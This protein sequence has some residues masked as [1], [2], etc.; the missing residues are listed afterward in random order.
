[1][2][3][4]VELTAKLKL[5]TSDAEKQLSAMASKPVKSSKLKAKALPDEAAKS[6]KGIFSGD[7]GVANIGK[8]AKSATGGMNSMMGALEGMSGAA[9][10]AAAAIAGVTAAVAIVIKL[11]QGTDTMKAMMQKFEELF[12]KLREAMAPVLSLIGDIVI[13]IIQIVEDLLP[14]IQPNLNA[15][16]LA[17]KPVVVILQLLEPIIRLLGKAFE[18]LYDVIKT[19]IKTITFGLID[20]GNITGST[21]A[22]K[23]SGYSSSLDTWETSGDAAQNLSEAGKTLKDAAF[24]IKS[25]F[26]GLFDGVRDFLGG[27]K[28]G[29][30]NAASGAWSWIKDTAGN[31]WEGIKGFASNAWDSIKNTATNVWGSIKGVA[32]NVWASVKDTA[33]NI[34]GKVTTA[35]SNVAQGVGKVASNVWEGVK[36]AAS[37]VGSAV[38][39]VA[40]NVWEGAKNVAGKVGNAIGGFFKKLKFWDDGGTLGL[41][42]QIWG[43]NEKGNPEF[44]F[45]SGGTDTVV[46][47]DILENAMYNAV[48]RANSEGMFKLEVSTKAGVQLGPKALADW[49]LPALQ[50]NLVRK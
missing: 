7:K 27:V 40:T 13:V 32:T 29:L 35:A 48:K 2:D 36:T 15:I 25:T 14:F 23:T 28:D 31:V 49:L 21:S 46:N 38:A 3:D 37:T 42:A 20:L 22:T 9:S 24:D 12:N 43:M 39:N 11:L 19:V 10:G 41:G 8:L 18:F 47:A 33:S 50:F 4:I 30:I 1:M 16:A 45:N 6:L 26:S 17:L 5:D 44:L 34:W